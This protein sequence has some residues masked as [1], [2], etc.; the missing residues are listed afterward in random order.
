[1]F[2]KGK[3][4]DSEESSSEEEEED[5]DDDLGNRGPVRGKL[6]VDLTIVH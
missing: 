3:G 6:I 4:I 1:M 5:Y 2:K